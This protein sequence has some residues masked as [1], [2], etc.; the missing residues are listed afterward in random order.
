MENPE[1]YKIQ[2]LLVKLRI[3]SGRISHD[4]AYYYCEK[5][6]NLSSLYIDEAYESA[7]FDPEKSLI[8]FLDIKGSTFDL[9]IRRLDPSSTDESFWIKIADRYV[10]ELVGALE[11]SHPPILNF[12]RTK[13]LWI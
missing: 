1:E 8:Q 7:G 10:H 5:H 6:H 13:H 4:D 12:E 2:S 3:L 11:Y 9:V